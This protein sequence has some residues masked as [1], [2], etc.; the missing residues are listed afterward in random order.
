MFDSSVI[1]R[2]FVVFAADSQHISDLDVLRAI[3]AHV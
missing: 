2:V 3:Q 1:G